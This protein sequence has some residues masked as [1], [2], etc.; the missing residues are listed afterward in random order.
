MGSKFETITMARDLVSAFARRDWTDALRDKFDVEALVS[1]LDEM[2]RERSFVTEIQA[3][4]E[5]ARAA[6]AG[7]RGRPR[8]KV[9]APAAVASKKVAT[10]TAE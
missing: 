1:K 9:M 3:A 5:R 4:G 2:R 8:K 6:Q 7:R 10:A